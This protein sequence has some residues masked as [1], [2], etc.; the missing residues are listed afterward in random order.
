MPVRAFADIMALI[1]GAKKALK[2]PLGEDVRN[3]LL[4]SKIIAFRQDICVK[5]NI[6][7]VNSKLPERGNVHGYSSGTNSSFL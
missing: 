6:V 1:C 7:H 3:I 5:A 4:L 2:L